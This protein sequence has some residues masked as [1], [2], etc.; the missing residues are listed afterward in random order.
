MRLPSGVTDQYCYFVGVDATDLKTRETGLST[1]TVYRS[2]N[3]GA[4][5]AMTTP[6]INETDGT[7]MP[8]V[9]E[10]LLD[11][12][13]TIDAGDAEQEMVF[14]ITHAGMAPVTRTITIFRPPVSAGETL[15]VTS[16]LAS[17]NTTQLAGQTVTA[18]AGVTFP[19]SV[20]S[21]TNI[22][23]ET[24]ITL[25]ALTHTG[26]V[27]PTVTTL[28]GHTAQTGD[29]FDRL[30]AP[31]GVSVSAD[32]AAVKG[33]T[34]TILADTNDIQTRIPAALVGGKIDASMSAID[35]QA[36]SGNNATLKLK[37]LDITNS[38]GTAVIAKSTG[39]DGYGMDVAGNG[40]AH[41]LKVVGGALAFGALI[42]GPSSGLVIEA[43]TDG[44]GIMSLGT[45]TGRSGMYLSG[46]SGGFALN[47][48]GGVD[49][50]TGGITSNI[51]G[52]LSGSVGSVTAAV[53]TTSNIKKN[54]ALSA[55]E[56]L[57]TD[58]TNH[59]PSTGLTVSVTRSIDGGAFAAGTLSAVTEVSNGIYKVD[60][61]AGDLNGNVIVL[62][63]TAAASDDTMERIITQP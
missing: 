16:G 32:V 49:A 45:G 36:T 21:P 14:H 10:L 1:F 9:Y 11:E 4:P 61:G 17:A 37:Q 52:N 33:E 42:S 28:T 6:T 63:A 3:G 43:T 23:A 38:A 25:A 44:E 31:A 54:Q 8:G 18:G 20:A 55:F 59:A 56:F 34:A 26:A 51:T 58:S 12:D 60:F 39:G 47:A 35:G 22:T 13:T 41:G 57:M 29:C 30:G 53:A 19:S 2:R 7:N 24:G 62:R 15:T 50:S 40:A 27:I 48:V 46:G 5:A